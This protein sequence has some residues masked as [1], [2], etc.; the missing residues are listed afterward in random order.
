[1]VGRPGKYQPRFTSGEADPLLLGNT[2]EGA[3]L[4]AAQLMQNVHVLPQGGFTLMDGTSYLGTVPAPGGALSNVKIRP[5]THSRGV[6]YD[7]VLYNQGF[8]VYG[9]AGY[10]ATGS[11]PYLSAD[12][13]NLDFVQQL[14]TMLIFHQ[15][16][17]PERITYSGPTSWAVDNPP[18]TNIPNY[19]FPGA[20]YS[21]GVP[22]VWLIQF[23]NATSGNVYQ[24]SV[25]GVIG[26]S[27]TYSGTNAIDQAS[28]LAS[29][30]AVPE[31][32]SGVTVTIGGSNTPGGFPVPSGF[33]GIEFSGANNVGDGWAV[34]GAFLNN[35]NAA[36][37]AAHAQQ[38]VLPGEAIMSNTRGWPGC[39]VFYSGRLLLGGFAQVPNAILASESSNYWQLDTRIVGAAAPM[40]IPIDVDGAATIK[41]LMKGNTLLIFTDDGEYWLNTP[42]LDA[43]TTPA[44][45]KAS[46]NGVGPTTKP[47]FS[48][49]KAVYCDAFQGALWEF[50]YNLGVQNYE[51]QNISVRSS[52]LVSGIVDQDLRRLNG[53]TQCNE[54]WAVRSD[55]LAVCGHLLRSEDI[56]AF[57]RRATDG[58]YLAV[59]VNDRREVNF[60]VK[61][62]VGNGQSIYVERASSSYLLDAAVPF[63]YGAPQSTVT[64]LSAHEGR[65]VWVVADGN[66]QGPYTV[67]GG[68]IATGFPVKTGYAGRWTPPQVVTMPQPRDIAPRTVMRR[69]C[70]VHTVR[71]LVENTTSLAI[72]ANGQGPFDVPV[73]QLGGAPAD[74]ADLSA[75]YTGWLAIEGL[76]G[77]SDDGAVTI[78]QL[79]PGTL[80]VSGLVVEVDL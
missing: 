79:R 73:R 12:I 17:A 30:Q 62:T 74:V 55:G 53:A 37:P 36:V 72:A 48:E 29:I 60:C 59:D 25:N 2:D 71:I 41:R 51:S 35:A 43:T 75:P 47:S 34:S 10:L 65:Q 3:Y 5:F 77:F 21:N 22:A 27:Q 23:F 67:A 80:T 76:Q 16:Y 31:V 69:P 19:S 28:I 57:T 8:D 39:G 58:T 11:L 9:P 78:T 49:G 1:M 6:A 33:F 66:P 13:A 18:W 32:S 38:G 14:D 45:I 40:L 56:T 70:R 52:Y 15:S 68:T 4:K 7:L 20:T 44:I 63:S 46:P 26:T 50:V 54:L 64:G 42:T 61:R 24:L